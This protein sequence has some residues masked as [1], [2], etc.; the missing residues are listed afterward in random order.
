MVSISRLLY[1][2][3]YVDDEKKKNPWLGHGCVDAVMH[4]SFSLAFI[5]RFQ[6]WQQQTECSVKSSPHLESPKVYGKSSLTILMLGWVFDQIWIADKEKRLRA[7]SPS[8]ISLLFT[9]KCL[10]M[11]DHKSTRHRW[12]HVWLETENRNQMMVCRGSTWMTLKIIESNDKWH[13]RDSCFVSL[14]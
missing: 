2:L 8:N 12:N 6:S 9:P 1:L 4:A 7:I 14:L 5:R 13:F 11:L 10:G 3:N